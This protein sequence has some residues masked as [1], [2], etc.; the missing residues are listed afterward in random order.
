MMSIAWKA[1]SR[2]CI[3][4]IATSA[5]RFASNSRCSVTSA[6]SNSSATA[7]IAF[8]DSHQ[9]SRRPDVAEQSWH[10]E[11][12]LPGSLLFFLRQQVLQDGSELFREP[13]RLRHRLELPVD[14]FGVTLFP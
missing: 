6:Y 10:C 3:P 11:H 4:P 2:D 7:N 13:A 8:A 14:V 9:L 5:T 1:D 12:N